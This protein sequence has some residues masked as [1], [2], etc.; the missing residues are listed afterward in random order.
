MKRLIHLFAF[1]LGM[2]F[3]AISLNAQTPSASSPSNLLLILDTSGSMW[4]QI[5][6]QNK[7]VIA[8]EVLKNLPGGRLSIK[9]MADGK[10]EDVVVQVYNA[11]DGKEIAHGR[12]YSKPETNP[13][14]VSLPA[15]KYNVEVRAIRFK[16]NVK[17]TF[18]EIEMT[19]IAGQ[20]VEAS[21]DFG[22]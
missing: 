12:T 1:C 2:T 13:R 14:I 9:A 7:I 6:G 11:E 15:G 3:M 17:Q 22:K 16:G 8:R 18:T 10:L 19:V 21:V 4:G 5:E 20:V